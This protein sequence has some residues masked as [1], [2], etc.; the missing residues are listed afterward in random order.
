MTLELKFPNKTNYFKHFSIKKSDLKKTRGTLKTFGL[1]L[2]E[3]WISKDDKYCE[4]W[5]SA[6]KNLHARI[7]INS[8]S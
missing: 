5:H 3:I 2:L 7:D 1:D 8:D 4:I 6:V